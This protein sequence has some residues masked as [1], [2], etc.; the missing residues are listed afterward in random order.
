MDHLAKSSMS[1]NMSSMDINV[2]DVKYTGNQALAT[3]TFAAKGQNNGAPLMTIGYRMEQ[4]GSKWV[5]V[6]VANDSG[7]AG[8]ADPNAGGANPHGGAMPP[9]ASGADN[10]HGGGAGK[11]PSP[12]DLPP[13]SKK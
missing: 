6:G 1:L 13:A 10:P 12:D 8:A 3:V 11:M 5:V 4:Q 7:H 2:T 9:A